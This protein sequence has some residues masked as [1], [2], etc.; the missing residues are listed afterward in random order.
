MSCISNIIFWTHVNTKKC[1]MFVI[2]TVYTTEGGVL[3][4]KQW[5]EWLW[6]SNFT[7]VFRTQDVLTPNMLFQEECENIIK[8]TKYTCCCT[9][10]SPEYDRT[11]K[12]DIC[13]TLS[14]Y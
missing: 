6:P 11:C 7:V 2:I 14:K 9:C 10:V 8:A 3:T 5:Q 4:F 13:F 1:V 12:E